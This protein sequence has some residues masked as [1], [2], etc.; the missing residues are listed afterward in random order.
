VHP[1]LGGGR[2]K[3]NPKKKGGRGERQE[4]HRAGRGLVPP[5]T[6]PKKKRQH[7]KNVAFLPKRGG[8]PGSER[9]GEEW[10]GGGGKEEEST[11]QYIKCPRGDSWEK[12]VGGGGIRGRRGGRKGRALLDRRI[13]GRCKP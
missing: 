4:R 5:N 7:V 1:R 3:R 8:K 2:G 10:G 12:S 11:A 6:N 13:K 9:G